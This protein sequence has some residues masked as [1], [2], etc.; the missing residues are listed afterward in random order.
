MKVE[1]KVAIVAGGGQGIG[2]GI[3]HCL[4]EEGADV[5]VIDINGDT[6]KKVAG[7]VEALGRKSLAIKADATDSKQ[8]NQAAQK[9]IDTFG[10]I[11]ILVNN[12][13]GIGKT[14]W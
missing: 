10:K 5:A 2:Q 11:D 4:A 9:V 12:V 8:V 14:T 1:G 7:E 3:V 13:G 6:A